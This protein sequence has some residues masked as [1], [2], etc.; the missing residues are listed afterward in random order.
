[1][2]AWRCKPLVDEGVLVINHNPL[3]CRE[4]HGDGCGLRP[5]LKESRVH[6]AYRETTG[7]YL[8]CIAEPVEVLPA[9]D[10]EAM[11]AVL[12]AAELVARRLKNLL[13]FTDWDDEK[14]TLLKEDAKEEWEILINALARLRA[15][16]KG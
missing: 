3:R 7:R 1:M 16:G 4:R 12:E 9:A 11:E 2:K 15:L 5:E 13:D 6:G 14:L 10:Y 8:P